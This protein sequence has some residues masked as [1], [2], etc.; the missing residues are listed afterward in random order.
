MNK[1]VLLTI[2][3][4]TFLLSSCQSGSIGTNSFV[5]EKGEIIGH[6]WKLS[7]AK[8]EGKSIKPINGYIPLLHFYNNG[9]IKGFT[10]INSIYGSYT[11]DD[12]KIIFS[13][14]FGRERKK[15]SVEIMSQEKAFLKV[16]K[17]SHQIYRTNR[18]LYLHKPETGITLVFKRTENE[19]N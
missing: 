7:S 6:V 18:T 15:G 10:G 3:L 2:V 11:L 1:S 13:D 12:N 14:G 4:S 9:V 19:I 17:G 16:I 8:K 5:T